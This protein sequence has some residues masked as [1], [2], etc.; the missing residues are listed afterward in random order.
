MQIQQLN[1]ILKQKNTKKI[2]NSFIKAGYMDMTK[3]SVLKNF[4]L[5]DIAKSEF[6]ESSDYHDDIKTGFSATLHDKINNLP[7]YK[8]IWLQVD[9]IDLKKDMALP[10]KCYLYFKNNNEK[11]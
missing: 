1:E 2:L 7:N 3:D 4:S 11:I 5:L 8:V 6:F 9:K 10:Y